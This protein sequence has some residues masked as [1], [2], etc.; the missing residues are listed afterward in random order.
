VRV[1]LKEEAFTVI[2]TLNLAFLPNE[3]PLSVV[4]DVPF[5]HLRLLDILLGLLLLYSKVLMT[6][7]EPS[8]DVVILL[9]HLSLLHLLL[10]QVRHYLVNV[11][12][13]L[14][15]LGAFVRESIS[16]P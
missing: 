16:N 7:E 3:F 14:L 4:V 13:V 10:T 8:I 15:S 12:N 5:D 11:C 1:A 9:I 2:G 6:C